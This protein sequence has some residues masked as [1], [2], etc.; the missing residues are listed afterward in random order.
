MRPRGHRPFARC[1]VHRSSGAVLFGGRVVWMRYSTGLLRGRWLREELQNGGVASGPG[2]RPTVE[3]VELG[4]REGVERTRNGTNPVRL[5]CNIPE[6]DWS[7]NRRGV[8]KTRGRQPSGS[9]WRWPFRGECLREQVRAAGPVTGARKQGT[10]GRVGR[11]FGIA[12]DDWRV[13]LEEAS[14]SKRSRPY[15]RGREGARRC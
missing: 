2:N 12:R 7:P 11:F 14:Q 4:A 15:P 6:R 1:I 8:E 9:T 5:G 3:A 10:H 13:N